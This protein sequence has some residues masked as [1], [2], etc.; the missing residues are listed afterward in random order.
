MLTSISLPMCL[1]PISRYVDLEAVAL[2]LIA[3]FVFEPLE[4][5]MTATRIP[6]CH[7]IPPGGSRLVS[8]ADSTLLLYA[9]AQILWLAGDCEAGN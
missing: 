5:Q 3:I 4:V 8:G 7:L 2:D 9:S 1:R 6:T